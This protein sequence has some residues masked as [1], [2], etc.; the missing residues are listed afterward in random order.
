MKW[1]RGL[2]GLG[3]S[4]AQRVRLPDGIPRIR[5]PLI[6]KWPASHRMFSLKEVT[7]A[8]IGT[9]ARGCPPRCPRQEMEDGRFSSE[10]GSY[11]MPQYPAE[12]AKHTD[13]EKRWAFASETLGSVNCDDRHSLCVSRRIARVNARPARPRWRTCVPG[14]KGYT[15]GVFNLF[16]CYVR[17]GG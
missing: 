1:N 3:D 8:V 17:L 16:W 10:P 12:Q 7:S 2:E 5:C 13:V 4:I 14:A 11:G 9:H 15:Y 6:A